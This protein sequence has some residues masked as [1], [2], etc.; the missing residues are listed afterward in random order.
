QL[1][2][3]AAAHMNDPTYQDDPSHLDD[4]A[5]S[6]TYPPVLDAL[7]VPPDAPS[8]PDDPAAQT[9]A[10]EDAPGTILN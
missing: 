7:A 8:Y 6:I 5:A 3:E 4:P 1:L 9:A 10:K 2:D